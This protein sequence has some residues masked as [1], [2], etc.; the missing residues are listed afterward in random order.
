MHCVM[1]PIQ[2]EPTSFQSDFTQQYLPST[3]PLHL[4][5]QKGDVNDAE[6]L[7]AAAEGLLHLAILHHGH[8]LNAKPKGESKTPLNA[9]L[10]KSQNT[11]E[12]LGSYHDMVGETVFL[13]VPTEG[14]RHLAIIIRENALG[15]L[16]YPALL[17]HGPIYEEA[18]GSGK[19]LQVLTCHVTLC[20]A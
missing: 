17:Y 7:H 3:T 5:C 9:A 12:S 15:G 16:L 6:L 14:L 18:R 4:T 11:S 10:Q 13:H 1:P 8:N 19:Q 20:K 2:T